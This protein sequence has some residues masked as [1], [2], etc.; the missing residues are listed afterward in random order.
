MLY[1]VITTFAEVRKASG[2]A[3]SL[4]QDPGINQEA[5]VRVRKSEFEFS[6]KQSFGFFP[7]LKSR[8]RDV[9]FEGR[10][11]KVLNT[12]ASYNFV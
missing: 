1:E 8:V 9:H 3:F 5:E 10:V 2:P 6:Y 11:R 7:C 4:Q 12:Y